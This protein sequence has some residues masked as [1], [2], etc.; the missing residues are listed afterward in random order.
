MEHQ[1]NFKPFALLFA[2]IMRSSPPR[3]P[4]GKINITAFAK[5]AM[6]LDPQA[7]ERG[8]EA[9]RKLV[10]V[11]LKSQKKPEADQKPP[12]TTYGFKLPEASWQPPSPT[13]ISQPKR[14]RDYIILNDVHIPF[15]DRV[16][17]YKILQ[18]IVDHKFEGVVL[19][20]DW[21]DLFTLGQYVAG[22]LGQLKDLDL[23]MEYKA[24]NTALDELDRALAKGCEKHYLYGNHEDRYYRERSKG[25]TAKYGS[26][27]QLPC[28]AMRL[29]ERGYAVQRDYKDAELWLSPNLLVLHGEEFNQRAGRTLMEQF[30]A[31]VIFGHT[32][33]SKVDAMGRHRSYNTGWLGDWRFP[34]FKY[35]KKN[36]RKNEWQ[37]SFSVASIADSGEHFVQ[38]INIYN[39]KFIYNGKVY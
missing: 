32:H 19:N 2:Q 18:V 17:W 20:G 10:R 7:Q 38:V 8:E 4:N 26:A 13:L 36:R 16:V 24:G 33:W 23:G 39:Q 31:S 35:V 29:K 27:F 11:W 5:E 12:P 34:H 1:R 14:T 3:N 30:S 21:L 6:R 9:I 37:Q 28:E 22:S 15:H 25:D